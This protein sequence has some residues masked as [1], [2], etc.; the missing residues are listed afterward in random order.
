MINELINEL[1]TSGNTLSMGAM[2][3]VNTIPGAGQAFLNFGF[4]QACM[5]G[6][7][8]SSYYQIAIYD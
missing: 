2:M 7:P 3:I 1:F 5:S 8:L 4:S 6:E